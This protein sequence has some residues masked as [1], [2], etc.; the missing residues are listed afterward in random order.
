MKLLAD[1]LLACVFIAAVAVIVHEV[2]VAVRSVWRS[3]R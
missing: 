3:L 2:G 1:L